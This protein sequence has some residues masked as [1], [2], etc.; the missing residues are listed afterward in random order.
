VA[1]LA[2]HWADKEPRIYPF[3][4]NINSYVKN[5]FPSDIQTTFSNF[6][7][8][9]TTF[10]NF[11]F[12]HSNEAKQRIKGILYRLTGEFLEEES[13]ENTPKQHICNEYASFFFFFVG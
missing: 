2:L 8:I 1:V 6:S 4:I 13:W 11:F 10:S 7:D 5:Q 3:K 9:Q 12:Q